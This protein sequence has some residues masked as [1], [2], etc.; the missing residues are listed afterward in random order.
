[1]NV[2][3]ITVQTT[4]GEITLPND[5]AVENGHFYSVIRDLQVCTNAFIGFAKAHKLR[6]N[7]ELIGHSI[8]GVFCTYEWINGLREK[9]R[10]S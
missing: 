5:Y 3:R 4:K 1:M 8:D 9:W 10:A 7:T 6:I 2:Y